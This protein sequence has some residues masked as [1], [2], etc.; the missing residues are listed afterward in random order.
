MSDEEAE[1]QQLRAVVEKQAKEIE[2]LQATVLDL[3]G[4]LLHEEELGN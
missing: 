1:I 2:E 4:R 3:K